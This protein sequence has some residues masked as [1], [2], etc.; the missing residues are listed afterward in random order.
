MFYILQKCSNDQI[1]TIYSSFLLADFF[2][3][4]VYVKVILEKRCKNIIGH[5]ICHVFVYSIKNACTQLTKFS[6]YIFVY[7]SS[8]TCTWTFKGE[9][10]SGIIIHVFNMTFEGSDSLSVDHDAGIF[11]KSILRE[12]EGERVYSTQR[13]NMY[14][15]ILFE[16]L[17]NISLFKCE[18]LKIFSS[19]WATKNFRRTAHRS[20][21]FSKSDII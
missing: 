13:Y 5:Y 11:K 10:G 20:L 21:R 18:F 3:E 17:K 6:L 15:V 19:L 9:E 2:F 14:S 12:R 16:F 4:K 1:G 8:S 7:I